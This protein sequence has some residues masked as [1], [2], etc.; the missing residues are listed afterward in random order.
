MPPGPPSPS[1]GQVAL[2]DPNPF[3]VPLTSLQLDFLDP[4][5]GAVSAVVTNRLQV[6]ATLGPGLPTW[7]DANHATS[8]LREFGLVGTLN[9]TTVLINYITHPAI[10]KDP[11]STL[12][13]TIWLVF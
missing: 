4:N 5:T 12:E 10:V 13:R 6:V 8:T 3:A 11:T 9:G 1:A 2:V 7:P